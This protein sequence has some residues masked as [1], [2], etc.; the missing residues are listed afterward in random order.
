RLRESYAVNGQ[1]AWALLTK[2][3]RFNVLLVSGL[4]DADVRRMR[5]TPIR[6][7]ADALTHA[8]GD[9]HGYVMPYGA[10]F[11]PVVG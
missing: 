10:R 6:T 8:R 3:E 2:A 1:T 11:M 7:L 4:D 5:M 9:A